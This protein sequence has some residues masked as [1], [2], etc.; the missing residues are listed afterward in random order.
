MSL[1]E[2][3]I[4]LRGMDALRLPLASVATATSML[5]LLYTSTLTDKALC[6]VGRLLRRK[7][8]R[9]KQIVTVLRFVAGHD[10]DIIRAASQWSW[11]C[12]LTRRAWQP[13]A[14]FGGTR[15]MLDFRRQAAITAKA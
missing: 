14:S 12:L 13:D 2:L 6:V 15:S 4:A 7:G 10:A 9:L 1:G 3:R 8:N 11:P 5:A